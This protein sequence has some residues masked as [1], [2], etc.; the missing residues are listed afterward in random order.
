[1]PLGGGALSGKDPWRLDRAGALRARQVARAIVDTG[2][3]QDALV[4][5]VWGPRDR[6]PSH[7]SIVA[8]GKALAAPVV[9]RWLRRFDPSL[10]ATWEELRLWEVNWENCARGGHFGRGERWDG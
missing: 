3:V 7:V 2:F 4:T 9:D 6:R 8:D 10:R 1:V 5:F